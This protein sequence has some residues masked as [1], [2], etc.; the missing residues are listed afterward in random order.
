MTYWVKNPTLNKNSVSIRKGKTFTLKI[1]G[2]IG[3]ARF[4]SS[5]KKIATVNTK[6]KITA[7]KKGT[8]TI[9]VKTNG[10][11]LVCKVKVK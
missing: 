1:A 5:N 10:I 4:T 8:V 6:G 11:T 3:T 9:K 2:K 7:K